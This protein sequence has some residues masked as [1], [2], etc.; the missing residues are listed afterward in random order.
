MLNQTEPFTILALVVH[1][2]VYRSEDTERIFYW[3]EMLLLNMSPE[4]PLELQLSRNSMVSS[5]FNPG[6]FSQSWDF[7]ISFFKFS[8]SW[9][10]KDNEIQLSYIIQ[11]AQLIVYQCLVYLFVYIMG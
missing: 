5:V 2:V 8:G 7:G 4:I 11:L 10:F 3:E 1:N 6:L 9:D